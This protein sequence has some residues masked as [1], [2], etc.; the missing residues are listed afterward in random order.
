MN[1]VEVFGVGMVVG[2]LIV[3]IFERVAVIWSSRGV[4]H[5]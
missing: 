1:P 4:Y 2:V 3:F 5:G